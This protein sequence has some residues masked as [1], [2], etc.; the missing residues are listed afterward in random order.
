MTTHLRGLTP[1]D[2]AAIVKIMARHTS[3]RQPVPLLSDQAPLSNDA[4]ATLFSIP[5]VTKDF[6]FANTK[7]VFIHNFA[8][9][10]YEILQVTPTGVTPVQLNLETPLVNS[11]PKGTSFVYP[12]IDTEVDLNL[13][14]NFLNDQ[15]AD[16]TVTFNEVQEAST[17]PGATV[18]SL[19][20]G[21]NNVYKDIPIF[22]LEPNWRSVQNFSFKRSGKTY[23]VGRSIVANVR[24]DTP[25]VHISINAEEYDR[26]SIFK[27]IHF[28]ESRKGRAYPFWVAAPN[29]VFRPH[30]S[31]PPSGTVITNNGEL[32]GDLDTYTQLFD[33]IVV[34]Q[35][36]EQTFYE[37]DSFENSGGNTLIHT[38]E[39]FDPGPGAVSALS[40]GHFCRFTLDVLGENWITDD[41]CSFNLSMVELKEEKDVEVQLPS[42]TVDRINV[43]KMWAEVILQDPGSYAS[44]STDNVRVTKLWAEVIWRE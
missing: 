27:T 2:T 30:P 11:Y 40:S 15:I 21:V 1:E 18:D 13:P 20:Y 4:N 9:G 24:G 44:F 6:R 3:E 23:T 22:P 38:V 29:S 17:L 39:T 37:I 14:T 42:P 5:V 43:S 16:I 7:R 36:D 12:A 28:F 10:D 25:Q 35:E 33:H 34:F 8:N 26:D 31:I 32:E 41:K 19:P